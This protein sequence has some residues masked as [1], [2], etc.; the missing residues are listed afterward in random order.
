[1][2]FHNPNLVGES[3]ELKRDTSA[4]P[5]DAAAAALVEIKAELADRLKGLET[6]ADAA[7][8][9]AERLAKLEAKANRP[10][11]LVQK[12]DETDA[13]LETKAFSSF[14]RTGRVDAADLETKAL[15]LDS[16]S[17]SVLAPKTVADG[18]IQKLIE[19]SPI[20]SI[21]Q[22]MTMSGPLVEWMRLKEEVEPGT[23]TEI[24]PRPEDEPSFDS[25]DV[26]PFESAVIVPVSK[27]LLEDSAIDL[28]SFLSGHLAKKFGQREAKQFV[29]GR[30]NGMNEAEGVLVSSAVD[31]L[32]AAA[33][34]LKADDLID[35]FHAIPTPFSGRGHWLMNRQTMGAIRK[36]KNAQGDYLWQAALAA[37]QPPSILGRPVLE[38]PDMPNPTAGSTPIIFGD[39]ATG[40]LIAD[41]VG[42][43]IKTD[44]LTGWNNGIVKVLARRRVGGRVIEGDALVKLKLKAA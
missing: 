39:F 37:G 1:M 35:L 32:D 24:G 9:L 15:T 6:K 11:A 7:D 20:R 31:T 16:A 26:K 34:S 22:T 38:A 2:T 17:G 14:L 30:G 27:T 10:G 12:A 33:V 43:E 42:L 5:I 18:V 4:D 40:Y 21:A 41:R 25:I 28:V 44:E 13:E 36:L 23:V 29:L 19:F 8:K 3:L